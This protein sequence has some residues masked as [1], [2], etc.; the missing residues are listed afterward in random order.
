[1]ISNCVISTKIGNNIIFATMKKREFP[2]TYVIIFGIL[3]ICAVA[4]WF[5]PGGEY[6]QQ[7]ESLVYRE[8][9]SSP[10][11]WQIFEALYSGFSKQAG[12][13]VFILIIGGA[14][15][16]VN[17][18]KSIDVGIS[19][20][21][22]KTKKLEKYTLLRKLGVNNIVMASIITLFSLFGGVFGMSEETLAFV[23]VL[24]PLAISMGYDSIV[25]VCLVYV[26]AHVGFAGAFLNPFTVGIAQNLADIPMFSGMGYRLFCWAFLTLVLIVV[27]LVYAAK[28]RKDPTKS[29]V[30]QSDSYW[31]ERSQG[32][33]ERIEYVRSRSSVVAFCLAL[34]VVLAFTIFYFQECTIK[35]A[36]AQYS[37]PWLLPVTALLFALVSWMGLRKSSHL[38]I[39]SLLGFTIVYLIIG[40]LS[41]GWYIGEISALFLGFGVLCGVSMGL[42]PNNIVKEFLAGAKDIMSAALVVGFAAGIIIILQDGKIIDTILHSMESGLGD[43]GKFASLSLMYGIQTVINLVIPSATAK[44]AITI[45]IMAPFAD[46]IDLSRQAMVVAFQFGDGFTN[47]ITPTSGVLIAA[48]GMAKIP[49]S[50]WVKW[51]WKLILLLILLGFILL[52]PTI[53]LELSGF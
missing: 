29:P 18:S 37:V 12:I 11:T 1:M 38:F 30:Y 28:I 35:I 34:A 24:V 51:V 10:Q 39:L 33:E 49:Y 13:I 26:A 5:V 48:L 14:F 43:S 42:S 53:Y 15:W 21:L 19:I 47:M 46:L 3:L 41:F 7:G 8:V 44:A 40:V 25:G 6:F 32:G 36:E 22:E 4:T 20:F 23:V 45:P 50:V 52:L 9:E 2:N 27:V 16:I 17:S 31:R